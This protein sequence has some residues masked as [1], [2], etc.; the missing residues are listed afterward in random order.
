MGVNIP[1]SAK[2]GYPRDGGVWSEKARQNGK[3]MD[4]RYLVMVDQ[5]MGH[6]NY[7]SPHK[8]QWEK[9]ARDVTRE[10]GGRTEEA[11]IGAM[12]ER[13]RDSILR[14]V[15]KTIHKAKTRRIK[16]NKR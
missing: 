11:N 10:L 7:G 6:K 13:I 2:L 4:V 12:E 16:T 15:Q 14:A 1:K 3:N 9:C 5:V 8:S